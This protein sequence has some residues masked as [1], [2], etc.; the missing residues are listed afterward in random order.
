MKI[1]EILDSGIAVGWVFGMASI[2]KIKQKKMKIIIHGERSR[3]L[4]VEVYL[5]GDKR[6]RR[7]CY[8]K[9]K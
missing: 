3:D 8:R 6:R 1:L 4:D 5:A 7:K 9:K 2:N